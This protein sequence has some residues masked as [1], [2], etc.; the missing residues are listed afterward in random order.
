MEY[1]ET[2]GWMQLKLQERAPN[3]LD[4]PF[5][6][7]EEKIA[8]LWG[9]DGKRATAKGKVIRRLKLGVLSSDFGVHP[10]ATLLRGLIQVNLCSYIVHLSMILFAMNKLVKCFLL[11]WK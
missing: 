10:V 7:P 5:K 8:Q 6:V 9:A 1:T 2:P 4:S 3:S 11:I